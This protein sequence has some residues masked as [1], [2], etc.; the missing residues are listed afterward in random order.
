MCLVDFIDDNK[1][2]L[3]A[4]RVLIL[5]EGVKQSTILPCFEQFFVKK[6]KAG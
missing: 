1:V 2:I 6:G 3:F 5:T 4:I